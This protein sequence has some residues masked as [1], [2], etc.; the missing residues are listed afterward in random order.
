MFHQ[1][2][3]LWRMLTL[4]LKEVVSLFILSIHYFIFLYFPLTVMSDFISVNISTIV[5]DIFE[6]LGLSHSLRF[7]QC[8]SISNVQFNLLIRCLISMFH[9]ELLFWLQ[10]FSVRIS[11]GKVHV[12]CFAVFLMSL[13]SSLRRAGRLEECIEM[14][15]VPESTLWNIAVEFCNKNSIVATQSNL[16]DLVACCVGK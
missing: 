7:L 5:V 6:L 9:S 4:F 1:P 10:Q 13:D 2:L 14:P 8:M 16:R 3:L 11:H 15:I 12:V